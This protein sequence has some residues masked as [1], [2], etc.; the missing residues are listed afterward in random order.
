[1]RVN[2]IDKLPI[3]ARCNYRS[4]SLQYLQNNPSASH[5]SRIKFRFQIPTNAVFAVK[6]I[7]ASCKYDFFLI[8]LSGR[9]FGKGGLIKNANLSDRSS[10][11]YCRWHERKSSGQMTLLSS[12][13]TFN[14]SLN[15]ITPA[16]PARCEAHQLSIFSFRP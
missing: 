13:V 7:D 16:L 5:S 12:A 1:M 4:I 8:A 15:R 11:S 2:N 14:K 3:T 9:Q 10:A 6:L